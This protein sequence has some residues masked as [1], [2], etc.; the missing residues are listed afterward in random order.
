M[1]RI[2]IASLLLVPSLFPAAAVATQPKDDSSALTQVRRISS[3]V[4]SPLIVNTANVSFP[5]DT[6]DRVLPKETQ[7][8]L[9][10]NID[11]K[12]RAQDIQVVKSANPAV[13]ERVIAAVR[14]FRWRPATLDK[15]AIPIDVTLKVVVQP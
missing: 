14:Q 12:G 13:D 4:T 15:Q 10:L 9:Q 7:V 1:R 11:E 8:V 6:F 3:G 5:P 2:L